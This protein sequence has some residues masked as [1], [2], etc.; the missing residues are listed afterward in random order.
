MSHPIHQVTAPNT[1]EFWCEMRE[2]QLAD[3]IALQMWFLGC[4]SAGGRSKHSVVIHLD[5]FTSGFDLGGRKTVVAAALRHVPRA[6]GKKRR[7]KDTAEQN[8][9]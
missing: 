7:G 1:S 5:V 9:T 6:G 3:K 8:Q 2:S 4:V